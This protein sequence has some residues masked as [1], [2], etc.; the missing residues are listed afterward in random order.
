MPAL[1]RQLHDIVPCAG[2]TFFF[3]DAR[4]GLTGI[5]DENP[6]SARIAPIY[7]EEFHNRTDLEVTP[8][9]TQSMLHEW[10]VTP[11]DRVFTADRETV[12]RSPVFNRL[13]K[14][15]GYEGLTRLVVHDSD[16]TPLG[17]LN[18][19][20]APG[21]ADFTP[22]ELKRLASLERYL[23]H[24]LLA[25]PQAQLPLVESGEVGVLLAD[26]EGR[27]KF[28][29]NEGRRLLALAT[30]PALPHPAFDSRLDQLPPQLV[31]ICRALE[32]ILEGEGGAD[33]PTHWC[34]NAW[35]GFTF[36][37]QLLAGSASPPQLVAIIVTHKEPLPLRLVRGLDKFSLSPRQGEVCLLLA[38][39]LSYQQIAERLGI[40]K[41][42]AITHGR[43][44]HERLAATSRSDLLQALIG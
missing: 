23:V 22:E 14:P 43:W 16:G 20:R 8:S 28:A 42:T 33:P 27:L 44:V 18:V 37:A 9:F 7:L 34:R 19:Y 13:L 38:M 39:G 31:R 15:L 3:S 4:G 5:Y 6:E 1:L 26:F 35:G 36:R 11:P 25:P 40:A 21:G 2:A 12:L 17:G 29:S 30:A 32:T 41:G 10:G 24:V